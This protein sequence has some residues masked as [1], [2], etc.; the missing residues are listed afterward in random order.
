MSKLTSCTSWLLWQVTQLGSKS[1]ASNNSPW[2]LS[3]KLFR[4]SGWQL[5][6]S[7]GTAWGS[8]ASMKPFCSPIATVRIVLVGSPPW[9]VSQNT[10]RHACILPSHSDTCFAN[11]SPKR[12]WQ[13]AQLSVMRVSSLRQLVTWES[14]VRWPL[15][16]GRITAN[17]MIITIEVRAK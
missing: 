13:R 2:A 4:D 5:P 1:L 11:G 9:Q 8:G 14:G 7:S 10:P 6:Q 17:M 3:E 15:A 12:W 16:V